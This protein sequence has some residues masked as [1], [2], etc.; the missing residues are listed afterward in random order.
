MGITRA[1]AFPGRFIGKEDCA[2]PQRLTIRVVKFEDIENDGYPERHTV[3]VFAEAGAKP[4]IVK[5][6]NWNTIEESYGPDS[7]SWIGKPLEL[8][9]DP[10]VMYAGKKIGGVRVRI[11][12]GASPAPTQPAAAA[13]AVPS[14]HLHAPPL[15]DEAG[16]RFLAALG[17]VQVKIEEVKSSL[18]RQYPELSTRLDTP[19]ANWPR[20]LGADMKKAMYELASIPF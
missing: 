11:P 19:I 1:Q 17:A 3:I 13:A 15:G 14:Q 7:D 6:T 4:F 16:Q 20:T 2:T 10:N 8:Y 9:V 18:V 5:P 12:S